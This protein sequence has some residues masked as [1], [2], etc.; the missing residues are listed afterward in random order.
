[1]LD[2]PRGSSPVASRSKSAVQISILRAAR[3][4]SARDRASVRTLT[5][6]GTAVTA[7]WSFACRRG[8]DP[9]CLR[10][11]IRRALLTLGARVGVGFGVG[12]E[13]G[14]TLTTAARPI[15]LAGDPVSST[16]NMGLAARAVGDGT[17]VG[18]TDAERMGRAAAR[19][20]HH[21]LDALA[22][23]PAA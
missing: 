21:F 9:E 20:S 6:I 5:E 16:R 8:R 4:A 7:V 15:R 14:E 12:F 18:A 23:G 3:P 11:M 1:M 17:A 10:A 22:R 19:L 2:D 13:E